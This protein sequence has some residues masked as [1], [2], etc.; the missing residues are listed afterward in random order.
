MLQQTFTQ[1]A[2]RYT[3]DT[4]LAGSLWLEIVTQ[5]SGKGR[6]YHT[7]AHL[8]HLLGQLTAVRGLITDLDAVLFTMYYHDIVYD[9]RKSNNEEESA[10]L[11]QERMQCLG[12]P[13]VMIT[14]CTQQIMATKQHLIS[15]A[16]DTNLFTDADLSILGSAPEAYAL[17]AGQVRKEYAVYP[18]LLYNPGRRKVLL[19]FLDMER[20]FKTPHFIALFEGQARTNLQWELKKL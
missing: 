18:D 20:I 4:G 5:Y 14:R 11:A 17:Y 12:V 13:A 6:Y 9:A 1:L 8:D 16:N 19:H 3:P 7:L 2:L 15:D 10:A